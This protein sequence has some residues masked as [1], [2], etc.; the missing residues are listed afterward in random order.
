MSEYE[1]FSSPNLL[2]HLAT[3]LHHPSCTITQ[4][5]STY[6][7]R[8]SDIDYLCSPNRRKSKRR[9]EG[10]LSVLG[11]LSSGSG[12]SMYDEMICL[13]GLLFILNGTIKLKY[14]EHFGLARVSGESIYPGTHGIIKREQGIK[15]ATKDIMWRGKV[16]A[17][18]EHFRDADKQSPTMRRIWRIARRTPQVARALFYYAHHDDMVNNPRKVLEEIMM[19][20]YKGTLPPSGKPGFKGWINQGWAQPEVGKVKMNDVVAWIH[21]SDLSGEKAIHSEA[22]VD[23]KQAMAVKSHGLITLADVTDTIH[24]LLIKW[25]SQW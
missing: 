21:N 15:V 18:V 13:D 17:P 3:Q 4:E 8:S 12:V 14:R 19:D 6:Y 24:T 2:S 20:T 9:F 11:L 25:I 7:L 1:V 23:K 16:Q 22:Y 10:F 5:G